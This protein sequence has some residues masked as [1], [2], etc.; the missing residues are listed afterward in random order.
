LRRRRPKPDA[1]WH[2]DEVYLKIAAGMAYL[3]RAV[4]AEAEVLDVLVQAPMAPPPTAL[5]STANINLGLGRGIEE[6]DPS[7]CEFFHHHGINRPEPTWETTLEA[8]APTLSACA[9][10]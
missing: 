2:L 6:K 9:S 1:V 10:G 5:G 4:D 8:D 7:R 3:W